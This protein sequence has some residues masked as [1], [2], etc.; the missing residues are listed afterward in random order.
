MTVQGTCDPRFAEVGEE[1][2]RNFAE[3]GEVGGSV[4]VTV[5]GETVVDL[6]GGV[7]DRETGRPW[8]QDTIGVVWSCTKGITALCAH[9]LASRGELDLD[10]PVSKYW[11]EFAARDKAD[12]PVRL[13][14]SHQAGLAALRQPIPEGAYADW[15]VVVDA[16]AAQ[17]PL[18]E[19]GTR[20]GY[21][22]ITF[23]HLV[24]EVVRRVTGRTIGTFLRDE[25][26]GPLGADFWIGLP[27]EHEP[28][29]APN[30]AAELPGPGD[31]I[32]TMYQ[33][34][35]TDPTSV[36]AMMLMN[37][38]G[39]MTTPGAIDTRAAH[40][41]E[42]PS[43]N[44]IGNARSL[45]T[46]YR[47]VALG[48]TVDGV[49]VVDESHIPVMSLVCSASSV[50]AVVLVPSRFSLGFMH[51]VDNR[52]LPPHDGING[53][54]LLSPEA[55]GH[56]GMGGALGFADPRAR[57]SFGYTMSRQG[58]GLAINERG[59]SLVDATYRALDYRQPPSGGL[60][61]R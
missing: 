59:Q 24:G 35:L 26:A 45:A 46:I 20:H 37:F 10:A 36:P 42:I 50:D 21:H 54:V 61:H 4:C 16:L 7:A 23:G 60:W 17:E 48:G 39:L 47:A 33:V 9:A 52:H 12:L 40:A 2:E 1:F 22:G 18:W 58:S 30:I 5:D 3:R 13:L 44:G 15:E 32:P 43:L 55:F 49:R 8:E 41:A 56:A 6:W 38:G 31:P 27:E 19:P 53:S 11:P 29:V 25:I 57:L 51:A 14:L 34:A 28:R